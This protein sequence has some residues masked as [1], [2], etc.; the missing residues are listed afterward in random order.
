MSH[1]CAE[2]GCGFHLPDAYPLPMCPW[3][4][5][6]GR[7][8]KEKAVAV[9]AGLVI[10]GVGY[11]ASKVLEARKQLKQRNAVRQGQERW[12]KRKHQPPDVTFANPPSSDT[13][14]D[15]A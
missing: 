4:M 7:D 14:T 3:H 6:P 13:H 1:K 11:G 12:R 15:A 2:A 10:L 9:A 5:A 8:R